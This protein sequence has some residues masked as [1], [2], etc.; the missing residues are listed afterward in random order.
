VLNNAEDEVGQDALDLLGVFS[1]LHSS[2]LSLSLFRDV[3]RR[4]QHVLKAR[5]AETDKT[6]KTDALQE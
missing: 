1:M 4:A 5:G 3:W 2:V 6:D